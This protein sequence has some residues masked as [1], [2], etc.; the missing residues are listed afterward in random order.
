MCNMRPSGRSS[1]EGNRKISQSWFLHFCRSETLFHFPI[2]FFRKRLSDRKNVQKSLNYANGFLFLEVYQTESFS[3]KV[4]LSK[5][6]SPLYLCPSFRHN[7]ESANFFSF[8]FR[9]ISSDKRTHADI[10]AEK[11]GIGEKRF[12]SLPYFFFVKRV[13]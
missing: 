13:Q 1:S 11:S 5:K 10:I 3:A 2:N 4:L 6:I 12:C 7:M 8:S 9:R